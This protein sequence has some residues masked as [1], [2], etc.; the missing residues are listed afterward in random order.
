MP[1][2]IQLLTATQVAE[3]LDCTQQTVE[4]AARTGRLP[5]VQFGR[6]WLFPVDALTEALRLQALANLKDAP[7]PAAAPTQPDG[8][9]AFTAPPGRRKA[10]NNSRTRPR[11]ELPRLIG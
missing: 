11:P 1:E 7:A 9:H 4:V 3:L 2:S 6:S 5:A 10:A 8:A